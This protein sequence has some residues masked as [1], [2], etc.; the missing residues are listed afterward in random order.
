MKVI[1]VKLPATPGKSNVSVSQPLPPW[2]TTTSASGPPSSLNVTGTGRAAQ[3]FIVKELSAGTANGLAVSGVGKMSVEPANG[4]P[5]N[6]SRR[7]TRA[8]GLM[9][10]GNGLDVASAKPPSKPPSGPKL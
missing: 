1:P 3:T 10:P 4:W 6:F 5:A 9:S 2:F 8:L 7:A